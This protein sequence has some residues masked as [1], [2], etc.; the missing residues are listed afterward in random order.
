MS[1]LHDSYDES[2]SAQLDGAEALR[3][4]SVKYPELVEALY[5]RKGGN[6]SGPMVPPMTL[7]VY[8]R[9]GQLRW[10]LSSTESS[11][12]FYGKVTTPGEPLEAVEACLLAGEFERVA[13]KGK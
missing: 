2:T 9:E 1:K 4:L 6:G 11:K 8:F 5:G 7:M 10:S 13:K 3:A 12:S